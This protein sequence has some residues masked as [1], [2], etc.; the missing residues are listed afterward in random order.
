MALTDTIARPRDEDTAEAFMERIARTI[1]AGA[2]TLMISIG[3]RTGLFDTMAR[4]APGTS[5][6]IAEAAGLSERYVREW[7]AAMVTGGI[8]RY[9]AG[10]RTYALPPEHA[11]CLTRDAPLGNLAVYA[12]MVPGMAALQDRILE[13]FETGGGT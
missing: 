5:D 3:H 4:L 9:D 8:V 10:R 13:C 6:R 2:V 1:D 12:Q 11:A 7:L